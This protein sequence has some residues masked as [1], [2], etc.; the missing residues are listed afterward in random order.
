MEQNKTIKTGTK[1]NILGTEKVSKLLVSFAVPGI[2]SML[3]N[4][5]Y[6]IVDQIFIANASYLGSYGNAAN[7]VVFPLTVIP[8]TA[9]V[10]TA[11]V[12]LESSVTSLVALPYPATTWPDSSYPKPQS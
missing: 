8:A 10:P 5:V 3:V 11:T 2:I 7:T 9:C 12:P 6:N 1:E 4:S